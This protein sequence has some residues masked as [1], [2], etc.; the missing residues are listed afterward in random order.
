ML[1]FSRCHWLLMIASVVV[2]VLGQGQ[3][4]YSANPKV[5]ATNAILCDLVRQ[6][7][8]ESVELTCL[9]KPGQDPHTYQL[10]PSDR[11]AMEEAQLILYGGYGYEPALE[12]ALKATNQSSR[13]VAVYEQAVP[14]P[15]M[16]TGHH[17]HGH[18][19]KADHNHRHDHDH[20]HSHHHGHNHGAK[21]KPVPDPHVWHDAKNGARIVDVLRK[22][23]MGLAPKETARYIRRSQ[24]VMAEM[25]QMD[26]WIKSQV[27]TVPADRRV[28]ITTHD[29]LGYFTNAYGLKL[30]SALGALS[31]E[32]QPSAIQL[33]TVIDTVRQVGVPVIFVE[34]T[35]NPKLIQTIAREANA[36]VAEQPLF[37]DSLGEPGSSAETYQKMMIHNT[38]VIVNGLGGT[39]KP[40]EL[41]LQN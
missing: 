11:R 22:Q 14:A 37:V 26:A 12:K 18:E 41:A 29:A 40:G 32:E 1:Y 30:E 20:D 31:T 4:A 13:N 25:N 7:A 5:V 8:Q 21:E 34:T 35:S 3:V 36:K 16:S 6:V 27:G 2:S 23:L 24:A 28:L 10:T 39:C 9:M 33:K 15:L 38:C 17:H 19:E